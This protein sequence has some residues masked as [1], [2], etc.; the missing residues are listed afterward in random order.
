M[1][2][3]NLLRIIK[4]LIS[5]IIENE[6]IFT[7]FALITFLSTIAT[8]SLFIYLEKETNKNKK[9][10]KI[11]GINL[12]YEEF[13]EKLERLDEDYKI[14]LLIVLDGFF[15]FLNNL[16]AKLYLNLKASKVNLITLDMRIRNREK[17]LLQYFVILLL[18]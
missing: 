9:N 14:I 7:I 16:R 10:T 13:E 3:I 11:V 18:K 5:K 1:I 17:F 15:D 2:S 4:I 6:H 12:I 8:S